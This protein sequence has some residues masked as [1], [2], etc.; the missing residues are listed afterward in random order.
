MKATNEMWLAQHS[1]ACVGEGSAVC[2]S[3]RDVHDRGTVD[4]PEEGRRW[5][6]LEHGDDLGARECASPDGVIC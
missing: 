3:I 1:P 2:H 4:Y 6:R 5:S